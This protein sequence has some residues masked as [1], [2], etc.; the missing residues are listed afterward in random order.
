MASG[1]HPEATFHVIR[2]SEPGRVPLR[3]VVEA[4][5]PIGRDGAGL[6]LGDARLSR[7][8]CT[9]Q[10]DPGGHLSVSDAGSSN[11]TFVNGTRI[12]RPTTLSPGDVVLIGNT[13]IMVDEHAMTATPTMSA[14]TARRRTLVDGRAGLDDHRSSQVGA[15]TTMVFSDIVDSTVANAHAGDR[16]WVAILDRHRRVIREHLA[17]NDGTEVKEQGDG[18]FLT[19]RSAQRG[20][21]FAVGTQRALAELRTNDPT[22]DLHVRLGVHTGEVIRDA[23]D[24]FGRH[25]ALTA[26]IADQASIDEIVTSSLVHELAS[27]TGDFRFGPG[28][29]VALKGFEDRQLVYPVLWD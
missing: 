29:T 8:H 14:V 26:R 15:T 11:G 2:V 9:F 20:L 3:L 5:L 17:L 27:S 28:R 1:R 16:A 24:L 19:F 21:R 25:V 7:N 4:R 22:F 10:V 6:V 18:F 13:V 23:G 12:D